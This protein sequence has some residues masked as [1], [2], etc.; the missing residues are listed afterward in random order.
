MFQIKLGKKS[1][2][3]Y[4]LAASLVLGISAFIFGRNIKNLQD[5]GYLGVFIANLLGSATIILPIPSFAA[6]VAAGAFLS[7]VLTALFS[8]AGSTIGE[9]TGYYTGLGSGDFI[10]WS[11]KRVKKVQA[12]ID[13]YGLWVVFVLAAIPNPLF[14][15]AG[16]ISGAS[17][18][19]VWKYLL[20]VFS[21]KLIKFLILA[22]TGFGIFKLFHLAF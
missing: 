5:L 16:I 21:G 12:W 2:G 1:Y 17:K 13:K 9:L 8:A 19:S 10:K 11:D 18:V 3:I 7:P 6:T 4:I 15:I 14:D 22:Y 20:I